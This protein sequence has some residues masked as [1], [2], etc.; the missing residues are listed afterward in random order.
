MH[1]ASGDALCRALCGRVKQNIAEQL[2]GGGKDRQEQGSMPHTP[3]TPLSSVM[4]TSI[5][6]K[7]RPTRL[8]MTLG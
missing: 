1:Y 2:I 7:E 5:H 3:A 8:P 6:R 4:A